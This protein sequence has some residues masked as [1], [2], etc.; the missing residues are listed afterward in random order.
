M[1]RLMPWLLASLWMPAGTALS[2]PACQPA[3][4][5]AL[6][7][8]NRLRAEARRCGPSLMPAVAPLTWDER[9]AASTERYAAELAVRGEVSHRGLRAVTLR[10][11]LAEVN[12][13]LAL[14]GENLGAGPETLD[15]ALQLWLASAEHCATLME[16]AFVHLGL[17]CA[18]RAEGAEGASAGS[19][20]PAGRVYWVLH[21]ALP[22]GAAALRSSPDRSP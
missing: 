22:A 2:A 9:L 12:Y 18:E 21:A 10:Q 15:Q 7:A 6:R 3:V 4:Q 13:P 14:A 17:A 5:D 1:R 8:V 20:G 11:R 19:P 16:P